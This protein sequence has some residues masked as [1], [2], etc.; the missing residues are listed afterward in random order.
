STPVIDPNAGALYVVAETYESGKCV[1]R[2]HALNIA[3]GQE[4]L[5]GPVVL[6]ASVRGSGD[7]SVN[8]VIA[9]DPLQHLQRPG[10]LLSGGSIFIAFGSHSDAVPYHGWMLAYNASDLQQ[11]QAV[12]NTT[13]N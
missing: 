8:S 11:K 9:F 1:L 10:L 6:E 3:T 2:L 4:M 13:A 7:A 5:Q 12:W